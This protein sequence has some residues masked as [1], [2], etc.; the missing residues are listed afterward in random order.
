V[1]SL[2]THLRRVTATCNAL[3]N[4]GFETGDL[5]G[6]TVVSGTAAVTAA[7]NS[8]TPIQGGFMVRVPGQATT[9]SQTLFLC[10]GTTRVE[11]TAFFNSAGLLC[12]SASIC[13]GGTCS[14]AISLSLLGWVSASVNAP[15]AGSSVPVTVN[16]D[17]T[18]LG[19]VSAAVGYFD[20]VV[21]GA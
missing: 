17:C 12:T 2:L 16:M 21:V 5:T 18:I 1:H 6:W 10:P 4:N 14:Q 11:L 9:L 3:V 13:L 7:E 19:L 8:V 20:W 15:V